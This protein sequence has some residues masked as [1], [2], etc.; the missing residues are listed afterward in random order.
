MVALLGGLD[1][2]VGVSHECDHPP[3]LGGLPRLTRTRVRHPASGAAI[4]AF[5]RAL[6]EQ[7]LSVF[8]VDAPA[9]AAARPDV[10]L[11]QDLCDVCAISKE[12]VERAARDVLG[13]QA[14]IVS[15]SPMRLGEVWQA[16]RD[17]GAA[18]GRAERGEREALRLEERCRELGARAQAA[19]AGARPPRVLTI[20]WLSPAMVGGTWMPDLVELAGGVAVAATAGA[21][22]PTLSEAE[23]ARLEVD[24]VLVKPCGFAL[25]HA[26]ADLEAVERLARAVRVDPRRAWIADGNAYFN[27]PGPRLVE[28]LEILLAILHEGACDDLRAKHARDVV[29]LPT[30]RALARNRPCTP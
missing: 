11:T 13:P 22:A 21:R 5:V 6:L 17:V 2:L 12:A 1:Q 29:D 19:L 14:R 3:G 25:E 10:V 26:L 8:E 28:S 23:L 30:A 16:V 20:E 24:C 4:D 27:R 7:S 18:I 9:L 15:M